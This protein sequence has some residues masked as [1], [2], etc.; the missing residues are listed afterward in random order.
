MAEDSFNKLII[1]HSL[2]SK[3]KD[4]ANLL[5][6]NV[7]CFIQYILWAMADVLIRGRLQGKLWFFDFMNLL[8]MHF[9]TV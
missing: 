2:R 3:L 1:E 6:E 9:Q 8:N 4:W 5:T 7:T